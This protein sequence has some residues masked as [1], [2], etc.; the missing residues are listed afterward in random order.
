MR[1]RRHKMRPR[2]RLKSLS[3][4]EEEED[5]QEEEVVG[6]DS[7]EEV[8]ILIFARISDIQGPERPTRRERE[9]RVWSTILLLESSEDPEDQVSQLRIPLPWLSCQSFRVLA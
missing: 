1:K 3:R 7:G 9:L 6:T 8:E 5:D 4:E 2:S